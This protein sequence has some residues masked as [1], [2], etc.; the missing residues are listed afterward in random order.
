MPTKN[1]RATAY[2]LADEHLAAGRY[3]NAVSEYSTLIDSTTSEN[4]NH[5]IYYK[6]ATAQLAL[7][8]VSSATSDLQKALE[9]TPTFVSA[10]E[11]LVDVNIKYG[12]LDLAKAFLAK[13]FDSAP[14]NPK[15]A[16]YNSKLALIE[17][18]SNELEAASSDSR[19]RIKALSNLIDL[20][21]N[22]YSYRLQRANSLL[23]EG[24]FDEAA[25]D[26]RQYLGNVMS[27]L[28]TSALQ[29]HFIKLAKIQFLL[30]GNFE[31]AVK[32]IKYCLN[33]DPDN[34]A[35]K[36][37]FKHIKATSKLYNKAM[38]DFKTK[39]YTSCIKIISKTDGG[40]ANNILKEAQ[41]FVLEAGV[42]K[43]DNLYIK[44]VAILTSIHCKTLISMKAYSAAIPVCEKACN[45]FNEDELDS[46]ILIYKA[47][48]IIKNIEKSGDYD[49]LS[50]L[51]P[52]FEQ[53][54]K[55][56]EDST[57]NS[58]KNKYAK[59]KNLHSKLVRMAGRKDY[60][61]TLNVSKDASQSEIKKS[62]RKL[63][64]KYHPDRTKGEED[65][66]V[67]E[68]KMAEIN[69]AYEVLRDEKK[70]EQFDNGIDPNDP[71]PNSQHGHNPFAGSDPSAFHQHAFHF[72]GGGMPF[73]F[74][75]GSTRDQRKYK[76][77]F[78][79]Q[80]NPFGF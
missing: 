50:K 72:G 1:P 65:K 59:I 55:K 34:K 45:L 31:N 4:L 7:G 69:L 33:S 76:F 10:A 19:T 46:E 71:D 12:N 57:N 9:I 41:D 26:L 15:I 79:G 43:K 16:E 53:I 74:S 68:N 38:A 17:T 21:P 67:A 47:Q 22:H 42:L 40:L 18:S 80:G 37:I 11:K 54:D 2:S 49:D 3:A 25:V 52:I 66:K 64:I 30:L 6:R 27:T 13:L 20:M 28:S 35:C 5:L 14:K 36:T 32:T 8:K 73:G 48:A 61:K 29:D 75:Q 62:Y 77:A 24:S 78:N 23:K 63:A 56:L 44:P 39:Q 60:Y 51:G 70:R 58:D